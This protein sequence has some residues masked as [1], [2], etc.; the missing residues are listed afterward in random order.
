MP[1][2]L[3]I[4][5]GL[6]ALRAQPYGELPFGN[7]EFHRIDSFDP[8]GNLTFEPFQQLNWELKAR[9]QVKDFNFDNPTPANLKLLNDF[10]TLDFSAALDPS[11]GRSR[12]LVLTM[13]GWIPLRPTG[14]KGFANFRLD[15][16]HVKVTEKHFSGQVAAVAAHPI[17]ASPIEDAAFVILAPSSQPAAVRPTTQFR[18]TKVPDIVYSFK[19]D[20][21]TSS[22]KAGPDAPVDMEKAIQF[23]LGARQFLLAKWLPSPVCNFCYTLFSLEGGLKPIARNDYNCDV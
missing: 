5:I 18:I 11:V 16:N 20:A 21:R 23:R 14:L 1:K 7:S 10:L 6:T 19:D 2:V 4:V 12:Y 17:P 3:L 9:T 8:P 13:T 15:E 22:W